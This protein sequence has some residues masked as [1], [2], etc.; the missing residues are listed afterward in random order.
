MNDTTARSRAD[1]ALPA[2]VLVVSIAVEWTSFEDQEPELAGRIKS[3]FALHPHH[4]VSTLKQD[5]SPRVG[6]T[7]V[8]FTGGTLWIGMM[9]QAA[10]VS[11]LRRDPRCAIHSAPLDEHLTL[12]DVR[13]QLS[14]HEA[15][16]EQ[17]A[18]LLGAEQPGDGVVFTLKVVEASVVRVEEKTL[19]VEIWRPGSEL[20]VRRIGG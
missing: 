10:R 13:L 18:A 14:A 16:P 6:G 12:G 1:H 17:A 2:T 20:E 7:N 11:D 4:V 19:V 8:F 15:A 5:G 3:L 9:P